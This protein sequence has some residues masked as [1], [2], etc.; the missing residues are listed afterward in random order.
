MKI[1]NLETLLLQEMEEV[2]G[3]G[4]IVCHCPNGGAYAAPAPGC[5]WN[6]SAGQTVECGCNGGALSKP[7]GEITP[8]P[9][10]PGKPDPAKP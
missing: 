2:K 7:V 1:N 5:S 6:T 3:G 8:A 9:E 10:V 4:D